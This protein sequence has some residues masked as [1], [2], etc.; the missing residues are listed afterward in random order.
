MKK[1]SSKNNYF[2]LNQYKNNRIIINIC[3][4]NVKNKF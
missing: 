4:S 2:K 1:A 3:L